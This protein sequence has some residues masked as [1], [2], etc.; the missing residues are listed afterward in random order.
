MDKNF[1]EFVAGLEKMSDEEISGK[2]FE[3][4]ASHPWQHD[5]K[6]D[7]EGSSSYR[8][9]DG[10]LVTGVGGKGVYE[11]DNIASLQEECWN[12]FV[13]NPQVR[14]SIGDTVGRLTGEGFE[15]TSEIEEIQDVLDE[16][17]D[18]PRN[19]LMTNFPKYVGRS[20]IEGELFQVLTLHK[21]G[22]V[23]IDFRDP[24]TLSGIGDDKS[25]KLFANGKVT[26]PICYQFNDKNGGKEVI[27][28]ILAA[29]YPDF[30]TEL[31]KNK[32]IDQK[33]LRNCK[34]SG[35]SKTKGYFRFV[36]EWD[37]GYFTSRNVSQLRTTLEW[38]NKYED[39][40]RYEIDHK[41]SSGSYLWVVTMTDIKAFRQWASLS[42]ADRKKT[43]LMAKKTPGSTLILPPGM[44]MKCVNPNLSKIS[45]ADTDIM[46]MV[47]SGLNKPQDMIT[48]GSNKGSYG[49]VKASRGPQTDRVSD[50]TTY[51]QRFLGRTFFRAIFF[52]RSTVTDFKFEYKVDKAVGFKKNGEPNIK[53]K[54][55][56]AWKLLDYNF[57]VSEASELESRAK[58]LLGVKHG[59]IVETLGI[60]ASLVARKLGFGNYTQL[61]LRKALEDKLYPKLVYNVDAESMQE[62]AEGEPAKKTT[63]KK[64]EEK[65]PTTPLRKRG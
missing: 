42:D 39:L 34:K 44:E 49:S 30:L 52:L 6:L 12:R 38:I 48:G 27:P 57:P 51:F 24:S 31:E 4:W 21:D 33:S 43:G 17:I 58:A 23:E 47:V 14:T 26:A 55:V 8:D 65:K 25:G 11:Q 13:R 41:K 28:G 3:I 20:E 40:K 5:I 60:P 56:Q 1:D 36:V 16:I 2:T 59:P 29:Y 22:F 32:D 53:K 15:I 10:F 63:E 46:E 64:P 19:D 37:L 62:S 45:D 50:S 54:K 35:F 61:R 9:E 7:S 18:D